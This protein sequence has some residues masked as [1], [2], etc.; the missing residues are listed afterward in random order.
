MTFDRDHQDDRISIMEDA[1]NE[2]WEGLGVDRHMEIIR[3]ILETKIGE[4]SGREW[5]EAIA[6]DY[7]FATIEELFAWLATDEAGDEERFEIASSGH[8]LSRSETLANFNPKDY[9]PEYYG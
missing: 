3:K 1:M 4:E 9:P 2:E 8:G 5:L 7:E 6:K